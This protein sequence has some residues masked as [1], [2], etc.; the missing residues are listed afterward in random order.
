[1]IR[2]L[3]LVVFLLLATSEA[4]AQRGRDW[5]VT[6]R[7]VGPIRFGMSLNEARAALG[8]RL[9]EQGDRVS[10]ECYNVFP[11]NGPSGVSFMVENGRIARVNVDNP[12]LRTRSG[13]GIGY[14][15]EEIR[16]LYTDRIRIDQHEYDEGGHYLVFVPVDRVDNGYRLVFET[17]GLHVTNFR[18]GLYPAVEYVEGCL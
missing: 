9:V 15:E 5:V 1:M 4:Y 12:T 13:A 18:A 6:L 14:T 2:Y 8:D 16:Q 11:A 7:S 10:N 3:T 17:D